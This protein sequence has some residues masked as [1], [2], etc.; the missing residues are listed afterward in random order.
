M[1]CVP[2]V[3]VEFMSWGFWVMT[4]GLLCTVFYLQDKLQEA[5]ALNAKNQFIL[6]AM[7]KEKL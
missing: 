6:D 2:H 3:V 7:S 1:N 5:R 4:T